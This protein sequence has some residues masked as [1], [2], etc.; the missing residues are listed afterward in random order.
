MTTSSTTTNE[1]QPP[2]RDQDNIG[3]GIEGR[4]GGVW[5]AC[6][7]PECPSSGGGRGPVS[8]ERQGV[9]APS[10][11]AFACKKMPPH[12]T[13]NNRIWQEA[14]NHTGRDKDRD[15][16]ETEG[17]K[18]YDSPGTDRDLVTGRGSK[19]G[20]ERTRGMAAEAGTWRRAQRRAT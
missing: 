5:V 19:G 13:A 10:P 2:G 1:I 15:T 3:G 20:G 18:T 14:E 8:S 7:A 4:G 11:L 6:T 17:P 12:Q 16:K 9:E